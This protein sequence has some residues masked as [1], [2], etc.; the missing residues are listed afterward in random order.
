MGAY[1]KRRSCKSLY[2][3]VAPGFKS[4]C[5]LLSRPATLDGSIVFKRKTCQLARMLSTKGNPKLVWAS[6]VTLKALSTRRISA[7]SA[8]GVAFLRNLRF[9][10]FVADWCRDSR[11]SKDSSAG[12]LRMGRRLR[13]GLAKGSADA[14]VHST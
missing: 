6:L 11:E 14:M 5:K 10:K 1:P 2:A 4:F 12:L 9:Q 13:A 3:L 8:E 7:E